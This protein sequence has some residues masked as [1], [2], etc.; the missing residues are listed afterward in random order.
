MI[1][2][3]RSALNKIEKR[4][5]L[6][7][8]LANAASDFLKLWHDVAPVWERYREGKAALHVHVVGIGTE[9]AVRSRFCIRCC[10]KYRSLT[11]LFVENDQARVFVKI[12]EV[13]EK[14]D[15][16]PS[17]VRLIPLEEC[18]M[19]FP[20]SFEQNAAPV[21]EEIWRVFNRK[22]DSVGNFAR[23]LIDHDAGDIVER[24][25]QAIC[26]LSD[27][28][29]DPGDSEVVRIFKGNHVQITIAGD[30]ILV[31][32][33]NVALQPR[34]VFVTPLYQGFDLIEFIQHG[35]ISHHGSEREKRTDTEN[36]KRL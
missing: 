36:G 28:N 9:N 24:A 11:E 31:N 30:G 13:A 32:M 27:Y 1:R 10:R 16:V 5:E 7:N 8:Y 26:E 2:T 22:L 25:S 29:S 14:C 18:E 6:V 4:L 19:F 12:G 15:P 35:G 20:E 21:F 23:V 17:L 33:G 3:D 34:Q